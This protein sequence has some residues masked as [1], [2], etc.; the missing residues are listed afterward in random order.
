GQVQMLLGLVTLLSLLTVFLVS[1]TVEG[2]ASEKRLTSIPKVLQG[3]WYNGIQGRWRN[4]DGTLS[5]VIHFTAK[6]I[7]IHSFEGKGKKQ[8]FLKYKRVRKSK[9]VLSQKYRVNKTF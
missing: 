1:G 3:Y 5:T 2:H 9:E 7:D 6:H 8:S 4:G